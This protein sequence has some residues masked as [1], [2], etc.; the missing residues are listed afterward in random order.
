MIGIEIDMVVSNSITAW[1]TYSRIFDAELISLTDH[2]VGLNE[3]VFTIL[4]SRFHL[5]DENPEY[6]LIAP[7]EGNPQSL[8]MNIY[9]QDI[10]STFARAVAEGC[11]VIQEVTELPD[12]G[13]KNCIF[14]DPSG[15]MWMLHETISDSSH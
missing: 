9:V 12:I 1:E 13:V 4:G 11:I 14:K 10:C 5:L 3:A 7:K 15:Y 6:F 2:E 8:W